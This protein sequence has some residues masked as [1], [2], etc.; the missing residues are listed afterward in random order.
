MSRAGRLLGAV[1]AAG[2]G[3]GCG[4]RPPELAAVEGV[5]SLDGRPLRRGTV[6]FEMPG[7]RPA[8]ARIENGRIVEATTYRPGDGVPIGEHRVAVTAREEAAVAA[9]PHPGA[10]TSLPA[11]AMAGSLLVPARYTDPGTSGLTVTIAHGRNE[12]ALPLTTTPP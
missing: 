5:V 1:L 10:A 7:R 3:C 4:S 2:V 11:Q 8:S 12:I 9:P 6:T